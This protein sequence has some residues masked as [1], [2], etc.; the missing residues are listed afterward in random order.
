[1]SKISLCMIVGNVEDYIERCLDSFKP[2]AD[3]IVVV[4]A[5][6]CAKPDRTLDI[7]RDKYGAITAEYANKK[8]HEDWDHV[9]DFAAARQMSFDLASSEYC[10]WCDSDDILES[11]AE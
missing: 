9:D 3:E 5:I 10:F 1:M 6:G 11:G 4:R 7:A 2:I 8:G